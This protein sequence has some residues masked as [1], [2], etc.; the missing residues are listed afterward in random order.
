MSVI[1]CSFL[2]ALVILSAPSA[3]VSQTSAKDSAGQQQ[4]PVFGCDTVLVWK[5]QNRD[6][7]SEFVVRI[8]EF[9][10]NRFFEWEDMKTQG[11][12]F[13]P[14]GDVLEAKGYISSRLFQSGMDT[15]S[16]NATTL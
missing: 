1:Q 6:Y 16:K 4:F 10:P 14:K 12:I 8:A 7:T 9:A 3:V 2:Y 11:T 13:L 15:R 5:T